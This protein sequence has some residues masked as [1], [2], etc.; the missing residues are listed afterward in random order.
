MPN[1]MA[2]LAEV[3]DK[4]ASRVLLVALILAV[5]VI[6][7]TLNL[8]V[9]QNFRRLLPDDAPEVQRLKETDKRIG[10]QS[11]LIIAI[12]SPDREANIK[13]GHQLTQALEARKD[14]DLRY[15]LFHLKTKFFED[16]ALLYASLADLLDL[17][18][19]VRRRIKAAVKSG[20]DLGLDD[21]EDDAPKNEES[22][23][24][25]ELKK[26]YK[27]DKKLR[28]YMEADEGK[29][30]VIKA[31]PEVGNSDVAYSQKLTNALEQIVKTIGPQN[32]HPRLSV[33]IEG[34]YAENTR[35]VRNLQGAIISGT[36]ACLLILLL[37]IALFFKSAKAI[38]WIL[39]PLLLSVTCALSFAYLTFGHLNLVSAFIFAILLGL[40]I[41]FG[42]HVLSRYRDERA[43]TESAKD[44]WTIAL[45]TTG[46]STSAGALST[47]GSFLV[48]TLSDFQGFAQFGLVASVGIVC[49]L[50]AA[51]LLM[52]SFVR[53]TERKKVENNTAAELEA[54]PKADTGRPQLAIAG[55]FIS[56]LCCVFAGTQ[57][58]KIEF[59]Y[60]L[61]KLGSKPSKKKASAE[62][63]KPA[64]P[65][66]AVGRKSAP[67]IILTSSIAETG[68]VHRQLKALLDQ[69]ESENEDS[70]RLNQL[71]PLTENRP[72]F[73]ELKAR[74]QGPVTISPEI[75]ALLDQYP[76]AQL[77]LM[78]KR[79]SEVFSIYDYVPDE[80]SVKLKIIQ[81]I[82]KRIDRKRRKFKGKDKE[83]VDDLYRYLEVKDPI[84]VDSLPLWV[85]QRMTD[86]TGK[87]GQ[88]VVFRASGR[89]ADYA[90]AKELRS[91]F[92]DIKTTASSAPTAAEYFIL[93]AII[94]TIKADAPM[95]IGCTLLVMFISAF[96]LV[97]NLKGPMVVFSVVGV[98]ML[99]LGG[100]MGV[101]G[102]KLD[103]FNIIALP[104]IVGMGQDDALHIFHRY[105]EGGADAIGKAVRETGS[106]IFLTTWTT[107]I[108]FGG[109]FFSNHRG[110]LSLAKVSVTGLILCFLSSV[111]VLPAV[112]R[113]IEWRR[114]LKP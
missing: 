101:L 45:S 77:A 16:N 67:G 27:L 50:I 95:V 63:E 59:E 73:R 33:Q 60:D 14:L 91:A 72:F 84:T 62:A 6:L 23:S 22:L 35:R 97:G 37:S 107:C 56:L 64:L 2:R 47:A 24:G 87:L 58:T 30:V 70:E 8:K 102:W 1:L 10:N 85:Q 40:G 93:A 86:R 29:V 113:I 7:S 5:P 96:L 75:Q 51:L 55:L 83:E 42:V 17:R 57:L 88:F 106:A 112:L 90:I 31:R 46:I 71:E 68:L 105:E 103:M 100:I 43:R 81:D 61:S 78:K 36:A 54:G 41:D 65:E 12:R 15:V 34:S 49:A 11:D 99:W 20:L 109:I 32:F 18:D 76:K 4:R 66:E 25:D 104:L 26:R 89:K 114:A 98:A 94:D 108:G 74:V 92:F 44:A 48:L 79:I 13:F 9:D 110:L 38:A 111:I 21:D 39:V 19:R 69:K 3:I 80:Q 28:E 53:V 52:P 82:R